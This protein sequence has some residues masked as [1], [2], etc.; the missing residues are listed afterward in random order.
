[1]PTIKELQLKIDE[2]ERSAADRELRDVAQ[3]IATQG[4]I[5]TLQTTIDE[6]RII[7]GA[8]GLSPEDQAAV[9]ASAVK[10]QAV[11]DSLSVADVP[12]IPPV[13]I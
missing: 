2:L 1:M 8:G 5:V 9:N 10:V 12:P 7:I 6:L 11:I 4:Q 3:D 13:L